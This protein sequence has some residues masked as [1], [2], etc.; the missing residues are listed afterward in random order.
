M[1]KVF[2]SPL[3]YKTQEYKTQENYAARVPVVY[4]L[5]KDIN[6]RRLFSA[7]DR[8]AK[9]A[10]GNP[11]TYEKEESYSVDEQ[12]CYEKDGN[13]LLKCFAKGKVLNQFDHKLLLAIHTVA[14]INSIEFSNHLSGTD[15]SH[16]VHIDN[17]T[18]LYDFETSFTEL[19]QLMGL[20][21]S[22]SNRTLISSSLWRMY[23]FMV[24]IS[25]TLY[26]VTKYGH[27][28]VPIMFTLISRYGHIDKANAIIYSDKLAKRKSKL[29]DEPAKLITGGKIYIGLHPHVGS[30]I[31]GLNQF[32]KKDEPKD[33]FYL[34]HMKE[35]NGIHSQPAMSLLG[36]F[37]AQIK[38]NSKPHEFSIE[39]LCEYAW[40][41]SKDSEQI[42][43]R[44]YRMRNV[45]L[46][47]LMSSP[48]LLESWSFATEERPIID[49]KK[50]K[51]IF[52]VR[53]L[54]A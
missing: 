7:Y 52:I 24:H 45:V 18:G 22:M 35:F 25:S 43:K 50:K 48:V 4:G 13:P 49:S 29:G 33:R 17:Q 9:D 38:P 23:S 28:Q 37:N 47:E 41:K 31:L 30:I 54:K 36:M 40:G 3:P 11:I 32:N 53:R 21:D 26:A 20:A 39:K 2:R 10:K 5:I 42:R 15:D 6:E 34:E 12:F 27:A 16:Q 44:R 8:P 19:L 51:F 1:I 14:K 46:K